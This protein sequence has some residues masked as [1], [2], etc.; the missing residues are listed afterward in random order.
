MTS[1]FTQTSAVDIGLKI[2]GT[3]TITRRMW[4]DTNANGLFDQGE[5]ALAGVSLVVERLSGP[6]NAVPKANTV[7]DANGANESDLG[8]ARFLAVAALKAS[9]CALLMVMENVSL[10]PA[11]VGIVE[12]IENPEFTSGQ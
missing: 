1:T 4:K 5:R 7:S 9:E 10:N 3:G 8:V 6:K 12:S 11:W 2:P